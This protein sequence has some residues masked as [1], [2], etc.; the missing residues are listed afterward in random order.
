MLGL[1]FVGSLVFGA[2]P[3]DE[4][5]G[6]FGNTVAFSEP[7]IPNAWPEEYRYTF[8]YEIVA[9]GVVGNT[10]VV[11]TEGFP[12]LI[13]GDNPA[14][15]V[16]SE[17]ELFQACVSKRGLASL[18]NG[19]LYP[20][21][22]GMV[23]VPAAGMP[24]IITNAYFKKKDWQ[25]YNPSSFLAD[26]YD[27]RYY[28]FYTG[29]GE[30]EDENG[31]I[32]FDLKEPGATFTTLTLANT[33]TAAHSQLEED[34]LFLQRGND[35]VQWDSGG[36]YLTYTWLSKLFTTSRPLA[37]TAAKIKILRGEGFTA[38]EEAAAIAAATTALEAV[39]AATV[40]N[41]ATFG[42]VNN[43][44]S[45]AIG[46]AAVG[47]YAVADGPYA[48]AIA[49][50]GAPLTALCKIYAYYDNGSGS[51]ERHLVHQDDMS[52]SKPFRVGNIA[53]GFLADQWEIEFDC[54][55]VRV[56]EALL[57][58]SMRELSRI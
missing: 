30:G 51:I 41:T 38:G 42:T 3:A 31:G 58:T 49:A 11:A 7:N 50:L 36:S 4:A 1:D 8:N 16:Q 27:D 56:H 2:E 43:F 53:K 44:D 32:V 21:P 17:L 10:V 15:M 33:V 19:V 28:A 52:D 12:S 55:N 35:I 14:S 24:S 47:H 23:Y 57:G 39:L 18:V 25:L 20:S 9:I 45:G 54:T 26:V 46:G 29:G 48:A 13:I 6:F 40:L 22:D 37:F 5:V 34:N